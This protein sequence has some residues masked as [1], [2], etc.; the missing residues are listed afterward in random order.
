MKIDVECISCFVRQACE[1]VSRVTSDSET[2][3]RVI[4][5]VCVLM[6]LVTPDIC[7]PELAE[8]VYDTIAMVTGNGDPFVAEKRRANELALS[9]VPQFRETLASIPDRLLA[10]IKFSLAG[11]SMDLGVV[12][13]YGDVGALAEAMIGGRLGI[14]DCES[15]RDVL[16]RAQHVLIVGDN[17]GEIVF[18][19]LLIEEMARVRACRYTYVVRGRPVI[20][21]VTIEDARSVGID[22]IAEVVESGSG[23]PGLLL[24][25]C[26]RNL[27]EMFESADMVVSKGQGNYESLS[28]ASRDLFFLLMV[29][30]NVV[31]RHLNA[32]VGAAVVKHSRLL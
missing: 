15:F 4:R 8:R 3:W 13:E 5:E 16:S 6:K 1:T 28:D 17:S 32:P 23:A 20:N 11:N 10:A 21:D 31:S 2:R 25:S 24:A 30:C 29:K 27:Q 12:R 9:L 19:R 14:D 22:R 7:P 26:A 18:D